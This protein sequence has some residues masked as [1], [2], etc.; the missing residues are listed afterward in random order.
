MQTGTAAVSNRIILCHR[1][2]SREDTAYNPCASVTLPESLGLRQHVRFVNE[3][4]T[5]SDTKPTDTSDS[6]TTRG[7]LA[8]QRELTPVDLRRRGFSSRP[9]KQLPQIQERAKP[10]CNTELQ[11]CPPSTKSNLTLADEFCTKFFGVYTCYSLRT[12]SNFKKPSHHFS[13]YYSSRNTTTLF[14][15]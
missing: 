2:V 13:C 6:P 5:Q 4:V 10:N 8:T 15:C 7:Q 12:T 3:A 1:R 9:N 14:E 11:H